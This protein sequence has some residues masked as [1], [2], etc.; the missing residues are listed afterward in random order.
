M[1]WMARIFGAPLCTVALLTGCDNP[2]SRTP[3]GPV[4]H[5]LLTGFVANTSGDIVTSDAGV[6]GCSSIRVRV[7]AG[8]LPADVVARDRTIHLALLHVNHVLAAALSLRDGAGIR[9]AETVL[10]MGYPYGEN[11]QRDPTVASG[12]VNALDGPGNDIRTLQFTAS[13]QPGYG[14][15]P[16]LDLSGHVIGIV[17]G[18]VKNKPTVSSVG[19]TSGDIA[20]NLNIAVKSAVIRQFLDANGVK[21]RAEPS[22]AELRLADVAAQAKQAIAYVECLG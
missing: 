2:Q 4:P 14:G 16:V 20:Q 10:V 7:A 21:Y 6:T 3:S 11:W 5:G 19:P 15:G 13:L 22:T 18:I 1:G 9:Q 17:V 8:E 12:L